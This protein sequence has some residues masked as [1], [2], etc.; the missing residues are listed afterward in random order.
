M[1]NKRLAWLSLAAGL[2]CAIPNA[3]AAS[4]GLHFHGDSEAFDTIPTGNSTLL[5]NEEAGVVPQKNWNMY[6]S[7]PNQGTAAALTDDAGQTTAVSLWFQGNDAWHSDGPTDSPNERLMRGTLKT[8][9]PGYSDP[10]IGVPAGTM[11]LTWQHLPAGN[12][13]VYLY[14][15]E[16][17]AGAEG[18]F[19]VGSKT[20]YVTEIASFDGT[21]VAATST[22][23]NSRNDTA[24]YVVWKDVPA[25]ANGNILI[26]GYKNDRSNDGLGVTAVQIVKKAAGPFAANT[27]AAAAT[28]GPDDT[29]AVDGGT[30]KFSIVMNGP[31]SVQWRKNGQPIAG[32][33]NTSGA[34]STY[35]TPA[36]TV[37]DS[38]TKY[39]AIISNN[40]GPTTTKS[41]TVTVDAKSA[42]ELTQGF[43]TVERFGPGGDPGDITGTSLDGLFAD[44]RW[45]AQKPD[46]TFYVAGANVPQSN[47][48]L[49]NF[50]QMAIGWL[51]PTETADYTFFITSDDASQFYINST[52]AASGTNALPIPLGTG[53]PGSNG[54]VAEETGC[55]QAFLEPNADQGAAWHDNGNGI[56]QTTLTPIHLEAGKYYGIALLNKEGGGGDDVRLAWRKAGDTTPAASLSP[57]GPLSVWTTAVHAG[58]RVNL[59][60]QPQSSTVVE[61]RSATLKLAVTTL[62]TPNQ[63]AIQWQK[64]GV[65]IPGA[66]STTYKT[67]ILQ[68]SDTGAKY[69]ANVIALAGAT[70][71]AEATVTVIADTFP[72][73]A[74]VGA[75]NHKG[76]V[77]LGVSF[78]KPVTAA[79]AGNISN[80]ALQGG[81]ITGVN[82]VTNTGGAVIS[83]T[84]LTVGNSYSLTVKN[85][86]DTHVPPNT[87][88]STNVTFKVPATQW[89][90]VGKPTIPAAVV[91]VG[92]NGYDV[93]SGGAGFW[94]TYDEITFVYV[95]KTNDFDVVTQIIEQDPSSQWARGGLQAREATDEDKSNDDVTAGYNFSAYREIHANANTT[96]ANQNLTSNNSFEAN[97]RVGSKYNDGGAND[98]SG[99][100]GSN[101]AAPTYPDVWLRLTRTGIHFT[102]SRS[103]DR[104]NWLIIADDDWT[105]CPPVLLVGPGYGPENANAWNDVALY[106]SYKI[107][108]RNFGDFA[109]TTPG[110]GGEPGSGF[111]SIT[112]TANGI[113]IV[114]SGS[115]ILQSA[116]DVTGPYAD[117]QGATSP[118]TVQ[119]T[120]TRTFYRLK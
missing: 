107:Q 101:L 42:P 69:R 12:Y 62:P 111:T 49:N 56:G 27:V 38:G 43:L 77:Q 61:G 55:C 36:L 14:I 39:D 64:N 79:S 33:T 90:S 46:A 91:P 95:P 109:P 24:N 85:I 7:V 80:Y 103:V 32:A 5:P 54:P 66:N 92:D 72:P 120:A 114:W 99:W 71:T 18:D 60:Q 41:A 19:T 50:G 15:A 21:F 70:N 44:P 52:A 119:P 116:P 113:S 1:R 78:D 30:A 96:D 67:P 84:G 94:G 26:T 23:P 105:N 75:I 6:P 48:D 68:M 37:A 87:L 34:A 82:I 106:K 2:A 31:W 112:K 9:V 93:I 98:T 3:R 63:Y 10:A 57:I 28:S 81:T 53:T 13:D 59:T 45:T 40:V 100:T 104:E 73:V 20:F 25:D 8:S 11:H 17:G 118:A 86:V 88:T 97:R 108:Y 4:I 51:K 83:V 47:P 89:A 29:V 22:D 16:N 117:V 115:A 65:D 74:S 58:A 110:G 102:G 76:A 35:T